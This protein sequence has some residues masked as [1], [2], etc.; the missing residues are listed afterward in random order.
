MAIVATDAGRDESA[1]GQKR[2]GR[3]G[4]EI[5][6]GTT[7]IVVVELGGTEELRETI[8]GAAF[9]ITLN[10]ISSITTC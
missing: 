2:G 4:T 3:R 6:K 5:V 1:R 9:S 10:S 8:D 7:V